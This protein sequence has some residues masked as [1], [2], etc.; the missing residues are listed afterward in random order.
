MRLF[1][2]GKPFRWRAQRLLAGGGDGIAKDLDLA[3]DALDEFAGGDVF[4]AADEAKHAGVADRIAPDGLA[5]TL[6]HQLGQFDHQGRVVLGGLEEVVAGQ[7]EDLAVADGDHAGGVRRAGDQRHL[8]GRLA[9][10]DDAQKLRLLALVV[11]DGGQAAGADEEEVVSGLAGLA[12]HLA[13]GQREPAHPIGHRVVR[14]QPGQGGVGDG[15]RKQ[16]HGTRR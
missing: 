10:A 13:A 15:V 12:Q 9:G 11:A 1:D 5:R 2:I 6:Q 3:P 7:G 16:G 8:A 14:K 4:A